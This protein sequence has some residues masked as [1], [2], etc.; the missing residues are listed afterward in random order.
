MG[1]TA[2]AI[3][4]TLGTAVLTAA[5]A[6]LSAGS[7]RAVV[8]TGENP[9]GGSCLIKEGTPANTGDILASGPNSSPWACDTFDS[10]LQGSAAD[11]AN[12]SFLGDENPDNPFTEI[13][14]VDESEGSFDSGFLQIDGT[15]DG[16]INSSDDPFAGS[17][18][19]SG[20]WA[21][22][23]TQADVNG[24][25]PGGTPNDIAIALEGGSN[26]GIY[27]IQLDKVIKGLNNDQ[28]SSDEL[29]LTL[30]SDDEGNVE[31]I[32]GQWDNEA[33]DVQNN[34]V[35]LSNARGLGRYSMGLPKLEEEDRN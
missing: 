12:A 4:T 15:V 8:L 10:P 29:G 22:D 28:T 17:G 34:N 31:R 11:E 33:F 27:R 35:G 1:R 23:L 25:D 32:V 26:S 18:A 6:G 9:P 14:K 21:I 2:N 16:T 13:D 24:S 20:D 3:A 19:T 7:A 30:E 5:F